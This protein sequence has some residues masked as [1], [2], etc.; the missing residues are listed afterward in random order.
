M[1]RA[2]FVMEHLGQIVLILLVVIVMVLVFRKPAGVADRTISKQLWESRLAGCKY[3]G[4]RDSMAGM[5]DDFCQG[6]SVYPAKCSICLGASVMKDNDNDGMID[7]CET[8]EGNNPKSTKCKAY[9]SDEQCC[10]ST[11]PCPNL[12]SFVC[13]TR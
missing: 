4:E 2:S 1:R 8:D 5:A 11:N 10:I 7:E 12:P 6:D 13:Q 9:R 3:Q